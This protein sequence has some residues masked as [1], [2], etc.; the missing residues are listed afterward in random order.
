MSSRKKRS[1]L[2]RA[3]SAGALLGVA[4]VFGPSCASSVQTGTDA[5]DEGDGTLI[6]LDSEADVALRDAGHVGPDAGFD[7]RSTDG[8]DVVAD[9][10]DALVDAAG[11]D[12]HDGSGDGDVS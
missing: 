1:P 11:H 7:A 6:D 8:N 2:A 12:A 10:E 3:A 9:A 5:H 4:A